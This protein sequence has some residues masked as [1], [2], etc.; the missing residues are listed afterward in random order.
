[1]IF[2]NTVAFVLHDPEP[3]MPGILDKFWEQLLRVQPET[4]IADGRDCLTLVTKR[5]HLVA[6]AYAGLAQNSRA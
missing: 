4:F 6:Q 1:M 3:Y 2:V 5:E